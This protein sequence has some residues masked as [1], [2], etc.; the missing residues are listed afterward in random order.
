M[1]VSTEFGHGAVAQ[2]PAA[3]V[4]CDVASSLR[5]C[6]EELHAPEEASVHAADPFREAIDN[7]ERSER[8]DAD[9]CPPR[10][11]AKLPACQR[12]E[13]SSSVLPTDHVA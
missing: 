7:R 2:S 5:Q 4:S 8:S 9:A 11:R 12:H 1:C 6:L 10:D 3:G 13:P